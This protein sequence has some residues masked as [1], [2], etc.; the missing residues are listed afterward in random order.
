MEAAGKL[1]GGGGLA[2]CSNGCTA[3]GCRRRTEGC[4]EQV[5]GRYQLHSSC[6]GRT[7]PCHLGMCRCWLC[8]HYSCVQMLVR[9]PAGILGNGR[10]GRHCDDTMQHSLAEPAIPCRQ[11]VDCGGRRLCSFRVPLCNKVVIGSTSICVPQV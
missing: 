9:S 11:V 6:A 8:R 10:F 3:L 1:A 2:A 5:G 4:S 7:G